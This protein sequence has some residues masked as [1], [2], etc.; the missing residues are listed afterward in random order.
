MK[1]AGEV[2]RETSRPS[3]TPSPTAHLPAQPGNPAPEF[4]LPTLNGRAAALSDYAG[5][6]VIIILDRN[7]VI[8]HLQTGM[9][10]EAELEA[11]VRPSLQAVIGS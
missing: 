7:G 3:V 10:S 8:R 1:E 6:V 4:E 2:F 5:E 11:I 9:I